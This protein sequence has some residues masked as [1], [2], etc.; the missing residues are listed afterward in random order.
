M[1]L[2]FKRTLGILMISLLAVSNAASGETLVFAVTDTQPTAYPVNGKPAGILVELVTEA[3][4]RAGHT[5]EIKFMPWARCLTDVRAGRVDGIFS[6]FKLA[7]REQWLLFS[8]EV[9]IR[10]QIV[11][12][13][14]P[15]SQVVFDGRLHSVRDV[16]IGIIN[17]TSY[18]AIF[19]SALK[20]G[21]LSQIDKANNIE[22][23]LR[24]LV[25]GRVDLIVSYDFVALQA[26]EHIHLRENI[27]QLS[28]AIDLVPGYLAFT[29]VR[30]FKK[31]SDAF[32]VQLALMKQDGSYNRIA[33]KYVHAKLN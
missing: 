13:S 16:K 31:L 32:D 21:V 10:Q 12:F 9:L 28:P 19:D 30:D 1:L 33:E 24:K 23:N 5:V 26:A 17:D 2:L 15:D 22:S 18:G 20:Q 7:G 3:F 27:R 14:R 4:R 11:F 25:A 29:R 6:V 8:Q